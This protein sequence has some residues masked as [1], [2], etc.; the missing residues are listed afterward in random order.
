VALTIYYDASGHED[1]DLFLSCVGV[2]A[3]KDQWPNFDRDWKAVLDSEGINEFHH[4]DFKA[5]EGEFKGWKKDETRRQRFMGG[6]LDV[7]DRYIVRWHSGSMY[8]RSFR[9]VAE[10]FVLDSL[11]GP[12]MLSAL[13]AKLGVEQWAKLAV[14]GEPLLHFFEKGDHGQRP[15]HRLEDLEGDVFVVKKYEKERGYVYGFQAA[16]LIAGE[17]TT[18]QA[19]ISADSDEFNRIGRVPLGRVWAIPSQMDNFDALM[20]RAMCRLYPHLYPPRQ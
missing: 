12:F 13:V 16:D 10:D 2:I 15:D 4:T 1:N 3:E 19:G 5:S 11:G 8:P 18:L 9:S 17:L 14:P 6:L 20:L 7:L